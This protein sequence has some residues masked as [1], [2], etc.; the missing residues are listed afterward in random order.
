MCGIVGGV[1]CDIPGNG[2]VMVNWKIKMAVAAWFSNPTAA[3]ATYGHI[4]TWETSGVT[5]MSSLFSVYYNSGAASFNEDIGAW[6]TSGV[7]TMSSMFSGASAFDQDLGWCLN[8]DVFDFYGT[9]ATVQQAFLGTQCESTSCGV[10]QVEGGCAPSPAPTTTPV[11]T[12]TPA[13]TVTPLVADD[14][15]IRTAVARWLADRTA[16]E[17]M[18]GPISRWE[19]GGVTDMSNLGWGDWGS[20]N[21]DIGAWDTSGVKTMNSMFYGASSFNQDLSGWAV[22]SVTDMEAMFWYA[23]SFNQTLGWC[24]D[25]GVR[26]GAAF[27][28]TPCESTSCGVKQGA[29]GCAPPIVD[30]AARLAGASPA[31]LALALPLI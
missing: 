12:V 8:Q 25:D 4:S 2:N 21:E 16:A 30:A 15:T 3:E 11:P 28:F 31:L 17:A 10:R 26:L 27:D 14:G 23:S 9:G 24:V 19:T 29:G 5:D 20:F 1:F 13:P 22:D 6:D 7:T 18:Y